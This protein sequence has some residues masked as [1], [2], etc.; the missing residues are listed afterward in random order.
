VQLTFDARDPE[1]AKR[2]IDA[3]QAVERNPTIEEAA[4]SRA[5]PRRE[6][7]WYIWTEGARVDLASTLRDLTLSRG[8]SCELHFR[9]TLNALEAKIVET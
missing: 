8:M 3:V 4:L 7:E 2:I 6:S 9:R 1:H 5:R